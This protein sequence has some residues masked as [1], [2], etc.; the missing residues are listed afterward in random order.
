MWYI[1]LAVIAAAAPSPQDVWPYPREEQTLPNGVKV[2]VVKTESPGFFAFYGVVGTGSRDEVEPGRSGYAHFVEHLMFKGT[3]RVPAD[4]RVAL[5]ASQGVDESGYTTDD[6]TV[7][8]L[9]GPVRALPTIIDLEGDR[10]QH[11]SF[12]NDDVKTESRAVLGEYNKS[13]ADP[14]D[15]AEEVLLGLAFDKHTYRHTTIGFA[16]D[17]EGMVSGADYTRTFLQRYYTPDNLLFVIVGDVDAPNVFAM[18]RAA[19]GGWTGKRAKTLVFDEAPLQKERRAKVPWDSPTEDRLHVGWRVPSSQREVRSAAAAMVLG[20]YLFG[21]SSLLVDRLMRVERHVESLSSPWSPHR[22]ASLFSV[23]AVVRK[24]QSADVVLQ[25]VQQSLDVLAS[26]AM[27]EQ[28]LEDVKSALRYRL[29]MR[30]TSADQTAAALAE[31]SHTSLDPHAI[32]GLYN[33]IATLQASDVQQLVRSH[34]NA[35]QRA[36]VVLRAGAQ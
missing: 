3:K 23:Q 35:N 6:A 31:T 8:H 34:F 18:M 13:V 4:A 9:Q 28:R 10:Y 32:D 19:F 29:L 25:R 16:G 33:E 30:L 36:V 14:D 15:K 5:L 27:D 1:A 11:L 7:Y 20:E 17:I 21:D 24:G 26:S 22:D 2:V 12:S